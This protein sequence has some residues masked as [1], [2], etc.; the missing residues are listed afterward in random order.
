MRC[1]LPL[2]LCE[3]IYI[4]LYFGE[5]DLCVLSS[6]Y[7]ERIYML[8]GMIIVIDD[9]VKSNRK[10][11]SSSLAFINSWGAGFECRVIPS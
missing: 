1:V 11:F 10:N 5:F 6:I 4:L 2:G 7:Y 3:S 8:S 9:V